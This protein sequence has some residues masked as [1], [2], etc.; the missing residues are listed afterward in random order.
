MSNILKLKATIEWAKVFEVNR[1][2]KGP[3]GVWE[4]HGGATCIDAL[5]DE[6]NYQMLTESGS[7][8]VSKGADDAGLH[9]VK[10]KRNWEANWGY[11][12]APQVVHADGEPWDIA[13][14]GLIGNGSTAV[15]HLDIYEAK[16]LMGTRLDAVQV[17]NHVVYESEYTGGVR[18]EDLS[19]EV[20][21]K[22]KPKVKDKAPANAEFV[23]D[24]PF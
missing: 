17:L 21:K 13:V 9:R 22:A 4:G 12:G 1:D 18:F 14:S 11:G 19:G 7:Q 6:E 2:M 23:D 20:T 10:F 16:G 8:K 15:I 5:L 3:N 24:I